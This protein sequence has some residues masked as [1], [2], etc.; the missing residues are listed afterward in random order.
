MFTTA[1]IP[2]IA[3]SLPD[4]QSAGSFQ[5]PHAGVMRFPVTL[6]SILV[7][8]FLSHP[9]S[10]HLAHVYTSD[11]VEASDSPVDTTFTPSTA[12]LL[13][14]QRLGIT[15]FHPLEDANDD[16]LRALNTHG[17]RQ[18]PLFD[19]E[20]DEARRRQ[21]VLLLEGVSE[22]TG[23]IHG[24]GIITMIMLIQSRAK[25]IQSDPASG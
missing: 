25:T 19:A 3:L 24:R 20:D 2:I 7:P 5:I 8:I 22:V 18:R 16:A 10:A 15:R 6:T 11:P 21:V 23:E 1:T 13:L 9:A 17:G 4:H 14:A 12:R